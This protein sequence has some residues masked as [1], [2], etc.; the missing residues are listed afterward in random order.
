MP[1]LFSAEVEGRIKQLAS[2]GWSNRVISKMLKNSGFLISQKTIS[3]V[4]NGS[5][6]RRLALKENTEFVHNRSRPKRT[7]ETIKKVAMAIRNENPPTQTSMAKQMNTSRST[8]NRIIHEDLDH[9]TRKKS[10]VHKLT[11]NH[12][13]I[14]RINSFKLLKGHLKKSN[15]EYTVTMDEAWIYMT[16]VNKNSEICYV[17]RGEEL[18]D[19]W[20]Y[21]RNESFAKKIMV[22]G[23]LTG[24]GVVPL[25]RVPSKVK[26]NSDY[27]V[28]KVLKP[29]IK[30]Y[31]PKLYPGEMDKVF[32]HHDAATSHTSKKTTAFMNEM[33]EKY[34]LKFIEK[35]LIPIKSPDASPLD[36]FGFGYLKQRLSKRRPTNLDGLMTCAKK[37]WMQISVDLIKKTFLDWRR[38]LRLIRLHNGNQIESVKKI[39]K[40]LVI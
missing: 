20:V 30:K 8:I 29:L 27:Y 9:K 6:K 15:L 24:R 34:G 37:E 5:G 2:E 13:E 28:T 7:K 17:K 36:Y 33:E 3:N 11:E 31:L 22:V 21:E 23:V 35:N 10:K 38:R 39:H 14:R 16:D 26:V 19:S 18:D 40:H 25:F 32:I 4:I 12:K 1:K